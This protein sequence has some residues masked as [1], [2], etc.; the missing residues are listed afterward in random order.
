[1][2][3]V[4]LVLLLLRVNQPL[5]DLPFASRGGAVVFSSPWRHLNDIFQEVR[6]KSQ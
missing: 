2:L 6:Y 5:S 3:P 1:M 4:S